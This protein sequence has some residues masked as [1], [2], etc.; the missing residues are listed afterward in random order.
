MFHPTFKIGYDTRQ[1]HEFL[2]DYPLKVGSNPRFR[3]SL[4][5]FMHYNS[6]V[7]TKPTMK[8]LAKTMKCGNEYVMMLE[9]HV[10]NTFPKLVKSF[11]ND[12]CN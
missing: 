4:R 11:Y 8:M 5:H 3:L 9:M 12:M 10:T 7:T 6:N 1:A 2:G